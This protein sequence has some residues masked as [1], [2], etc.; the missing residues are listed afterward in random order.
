MKNQMTTAII[1]SLI[2]GLSACHDNPEIPMRFATYNIRYDN[3]TD[4]L[5]AWA[6]RK[7]KV[8]DLIRSCSPH[9]FGVQEALEHQTADLG[10]MLPDYDRYGVG[11]SDGKA[12]GEQTTIFYKKEKFEL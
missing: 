1:F 8:A 9:I 3:P 7:E 10:A 5:H 6:L 4:T 2:I 11:R 12:T